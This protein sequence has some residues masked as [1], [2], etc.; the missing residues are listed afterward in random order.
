MS[1][2]SNSLKC[3][4]ISL[5]CTTQVTSKKLNIFDLFISFKYINITNQRKTWL[6]QAIQS[7]YLFG[8]VEPYTLLVGGNSSQLQ[9]IKLSWSRGNLKSPIGFLINSVSKLVEYIFVI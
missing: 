6:I 7:C 3:L 8:H 9:L 4:A 1:K 2:S 5:L